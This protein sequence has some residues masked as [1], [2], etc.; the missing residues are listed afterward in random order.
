MT[1]N[2]YDDL[3]ARRYLSQSVIRYK[4]DAIFV[5]EASTRRLRYRNL[6]EAEFTLDDVEA[7]TVPIDDPGLDLSP[8]PNGYVNITLPDK[9]KAAYIYRSPV[10]NWKLGLA[11]GNISSWQ[12][13]RCVPSRWAC[14]AALANRGL[15]LM[16]KHIYPSY[17]EAL[18][19][20][21]SDLSDIAISRNLCVDNKFHLHYRR[22]KGVGKVNKDNG[23]VTLKNDYSYL[24]QVLDKEGLVCK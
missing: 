20:L 13:D 1:M 19:L 23:I 12:P 11:L 2:F 6:M 22:Q 4:G 16:V 15:A 24:S 3:S 9:K 5:L 21:G 7:H 14:T 8:I 17:L 18:S 10:R